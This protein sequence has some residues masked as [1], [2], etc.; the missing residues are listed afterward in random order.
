MSPRNTVLH[1]ST[2][3]TDSIPSNASPFDT[4]TLV[5]FGK[6][7]KTYCEQE[8]RQNAFVWNSVSMFHGYSIQSRMIYCF[9]V[10]AGLLEHV[11]DTRYR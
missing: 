7:I 9:S 2:H 5:S 8:N 1:L 3:Y 4:K 10:T 11:C 6:Y